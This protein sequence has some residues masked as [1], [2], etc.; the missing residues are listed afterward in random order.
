MPN[1]KIKIFYAAIV[2]IF[3]FHILNVNSY[4]KISAQAQNVII[5]NIKIYP[6]SFNATITWDTDVPSNI[7]V[8]YGEN[9][10]SY[11]KSNPQFLTSHTA[12]LDFNL[13]PNI[14][15][16]FYVRAC[17]NSTS[18]KCA[19]SNNMTLI[20]IS[21]GE[22]WRCFNSSNI[23]YVN[24]SCTWDLGSIAYC[25]KG[26]ES[27]SCKDSG[28]HGTLYVNS[29]PQNAL[30]YLNN[31]RKQIT[32][33]VFMSL[34][35]GSYDIKLVK[36]AFQ[37]YSTKMELALGKISMLQANMVVKLFCNDTDDGQVSGTKGYSYDPFKKF[38][39][40]CLSTSLL[41]ESICDEKTSMASTI[42]I[43]CKEGC[44]DGKC[45]ST[46]KC[47]DS[48]LENSCSAS[49]PLYCQNANLV[50]KCGK[51]GCS[52]GM[53]CYPDGS[54]SSKKP[55]TAPASIGFLTLIAMLLVLF[56]AAYKRL[57]KN[58]LKKRKKL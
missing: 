27:N 39:D 37:D 10:F 18:V 49:K 45:K 30:I 1:T 46:K 31:E 26:C 50:N 44:K 35:P 6:S 57:N 52:K 24:Q 3:L 23:G 33:Y 36:D 28:Q 7:T 51:C 56:I 58:Q 25:E 5:S 20:T 41:N 19:A 42:V 40:K 12:L 14:K 22:S 55:K 11:L 53:Y 43:D 29:I 13:Q 9:T 4:T 32:P 15:Y 8:Y 47:S 48:T 17:T 21:C 16:F 34:K 54:C 38:I 2:L